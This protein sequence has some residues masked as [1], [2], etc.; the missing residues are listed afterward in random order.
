MD[1]YA[2]YMKKHPEQFK[3]TAV[4]ECDE[5]RRNDFSEQ[6]C[7]PENMRFESYQDFFEMPRMCDCVLIC[8]QDKQHFE[9][10]MLAMNKG[11]HIYLEKPVSADIGELKRLEQCAERSR[12]TGKS[13]K[14]ADFKDKYFK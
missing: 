6:F 10:A 9:P 2:P 4:A 3:I 11:Y 1:A 5:K 8:T 14:I 12:L 13:E 7:V